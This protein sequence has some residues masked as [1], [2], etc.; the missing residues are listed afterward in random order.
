MKVVTL[1][2]GKAWAA[3]WTDGFYSRQTDIK[4]PAQIQGLK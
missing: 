2:K 4:Y 1:G 3:I